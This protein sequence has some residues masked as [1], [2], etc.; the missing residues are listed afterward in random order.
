MRRILFICKGHSNVAGAQLY[1]KHLSPIFSKN[2][3]ELYFALK[4]N[5]G[6]RFIEEISMN[7]HTHSIEYDWRHLGF[8]RSFHE[9]RAIF[10]KVQPDLIVFN[11]AEDEIL[12]PIWASRFTKKSKKVMIVH[13]AQSE[14]DLP[15]FSGK[16]KLKIPIPSRYAIK[17]RLIRAWSYQALDHLIFVNQMTR[18]AYLKLYR[19]NRSK[20]TTIYNGVD[21][22]DFYN[23]E[24]RADTRRKLNLDPMD[25]MLLSTGNLTEVKGHTYL[26]S[27]VA[28]LIEKGLRIKCFI[29]GQGLLENDLS[30]QIKKFGLSNVVMLLGYRNDVAELL[31]ACDLFCM[32][33]LNEA[34]GYSLIEAMAVGKPIVA[35]DVGGIPEV[36]S[37]GKEGLL[38]RPKDAKTLSDTIE[39]LL[40]DTSLMNELGSNALQKVKN[41]FSISRMQE[42]SK[43]LFEK[44]LNENK[45]I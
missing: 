34:L 37:H 32:P 43:K 23:T 2:S 22:S 24:K 36:V 9:G 35:S 16:R 7:C 15:I 26:I 33:S 17:K 3:Y 40:S 31:N 10:K 42:T 13:W 20:C 5:N 25:V 27:A 30:E 8:L 4:K 29:A 11:S 21:F 1:L 6:M 38:V 39:S 12:A 18:S 28:R 19:L 44:V 41:R 45:T 14:K